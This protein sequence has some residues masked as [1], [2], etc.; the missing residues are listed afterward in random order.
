MRI[1]LKNGKEVMRGPWL[2]AKGGGNDYDMGIYVEDP[3]QNGRIR[4][5]CG[6]TIRIM[7]VTVPS[8]SYGIKL[9]KFEV[10]EQ[11][12]WTEKLITAAVRKLLDEER[13]QNSFAYVAANLAVVLRKP[14]ELK[15]SNGS[16]I[17][18]SLRHKLTLPTTLQ[19]V[20]DA[21]DASGDTSEVVVL[22]IENVSSDIWP[23]PPKPIW[24]KNS[25]IWGKTLEALV[26]SYLRILAG[27]ADGGIA[28]QITIV[29]TELSNHTE[30]SSTWRRLSAMLYGLPLEHQTDPRIIQAISLIEEV[31][32]AP[33]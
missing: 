33:S 19:I 20:G 17:V 32:K 2:Q 6:D 7:K 16:R 14:K 3:A 8:S 27:F 1:R 29:V 25:D 22:T 9:P 5:C 18:G 24:E 21:R 15:L 13:F 4:R 26:I 28:R 23:A 30:W 31:C 11:E 12:L 10:F